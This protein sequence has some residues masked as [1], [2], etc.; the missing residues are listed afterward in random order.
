M[1]K[2]SRNKKN[3]GLKRRDIERLLVA[4]AAVAP[5]SPGLL[6]GLNRMLPKGNME[7]FL[8]GLAIGGGLA[9]LLSDEALRGKLLKGV[10]G[11][12]T[13]LTGGL[14]E[15]QEQIADLQAEVQ[16]ERSGLA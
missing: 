15:M 5:P 12:Y 11:A 2:K 4:Q 9:Y 7:Q 3:K 10:I 6:G 16:A 13:D 8:L 14:A 1:A